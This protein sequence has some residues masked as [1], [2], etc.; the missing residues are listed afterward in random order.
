MYVCVDLGASGTRFAGCQGEIKTMPNNTA[1]LSMDEP[2]TLKP[3]DNTWKAGLEVIIEKH[4][5]NNEIFPAHFLLGELA[6][7]SSKTNVFPQGMERKMSQKVN[8]CSLITAIAIGVLE[9]HG[10]TTEEIQVEAYLALPPTEANSDRDSVNEYVKGK[11]TVKLPKF[12]VQLTFNVSNTSVYEESFLSLLS[13]FFDIQGKT[14]PAA[15]KYMQGCVMSLDIG[16]STCDLAVVENLKYLEKTGKTY[17]IGGN[18]TRENLKD[19]ILAKY[20]YELNSKT[21]EMVMAE[22]R[23]P[24]GNKYEDVSGEVIAAKMKCA[25]EIVNSIV[26]YFRLIDIPLTSIRA[27]IVSGGGSMESQ[28][29]DDNGNVVVTAPPITQYITDRLRK[30][31]EGIEVEQYDDNPRTANIKGLLVRA[32]LDVRMKTQQVQPVLG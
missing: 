7:R 23:M 1:F 4:G 3:Y 9:Q 17:R 26:T 6:E 19:S 12:N 5:V 13:Y 28:Y 32:G 8:L 2:I 10:A 30:H 25:D 29:V 18:F 27:V 15:A 21:C 20:G 22:G 16:A 11:Y 14:K 31:C 24:I